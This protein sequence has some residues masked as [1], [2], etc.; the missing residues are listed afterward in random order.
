MRPATHA[1]ETRLGDVLIEMG[2]VTATQV[3]EAAER[4]RTGDARPL[5]ELLVALGFA[6]RE[7]VDLALMRQRAQRGQLGHVEGLRLLDEAGQTARRAS[8][9]ID[10]LAAAAAELGNGGKR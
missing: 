4:Q 6:G 8:G 5:G 10:E 1:P 7:D 3:A 9:C 2:V